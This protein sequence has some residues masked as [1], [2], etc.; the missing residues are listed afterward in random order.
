MTH[1]TTN[2][3]DSLPPHS[4]D[5]EKGVLGCILLQPDLIDQCIQQGISLQSFY[6]VRHRNLWESYLA[7]HEQRKAIDIPIL[8]THLRDC[9][10]L[11][12]IG[13]SSYLLD[14]QDYVPSASN[15]EHYL[16][17]VT[18]KAR[19]RAV[20]KLCATATS[21]IYENPADPTEA[22]DQIEAGLLHIMEATAF[23]TRKTVFDAKELVQIAIDT[24]D[25]YVRGT[26]IQEGISTGYQYLDKMLGGLHE[27]D[28]FVLAGR[29]GT[30][31]STMAA[32]IMERVSVDHQ[33]PVYFFS[34]EMS[35]RDIAGRLCFQRVGAN[36]QKYRTGG[37]TDS[38]FQKITAGL[39]TL[40]QGKHIV[41]TRETLN[42]MELRSLCRAAV[43]K[44]GIRLCIIDYLQLL[45]PSRR[46]NSREQEIADISGGIRSLAKEIKVP[47]IVLAQL[48]RDMEKDQYADGS[49]RMPRLS[50]LRESGTVE[51]DA[52]QVGILYRPR[53][54]DQQKEQEERWACSWDDKSIYVNLALLKNR[55]GPT[56]DIN[57]I[58]KKASMQFRDL[59][60]PEKN[61]EPDHPIAGG[62][63][64]PGSQLD[65]SDYAE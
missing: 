35:E 30:G 41:D 57:F 34:L 37:L 52:H 64:R 2:H 48:N 21:A 3:T 17:E 20:L 45:Q 28:M 42:V 49:N 40:A 44:Y 59:K 50:D 36:F 13:G 60:D 54:T 10:K 46:Y 38:D 51:Q 12:H 9:D 55:H 26:G 5:A 16:A 58:F 15:L 14:V 47:F 53:L 11:D 18:L 8:I 56:G 27:A 32:N 61:D 7:L 62:T 39:P 22:V 6:D 43:K 19:A 23:S 1:L 24:M 25:N 63:R 65:M 4:P 31:K 29:P 33:L